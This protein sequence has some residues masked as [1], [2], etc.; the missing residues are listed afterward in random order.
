MKF[1]T[2][3]IIAVLVAGS[4]YLLGTDFDL[5]DK[6]A[7]PNVDVSV[8]A[9]GGR[10]P[11][12]DVNTPDISVNMEPKSVEVPDVDVSMEEKTINIPTVDFNAA[13]DSAIDEA[14]ESDAEER[15]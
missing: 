8:D 11:D 5:K 7:L 12:V 9:E 13:E 15:E 1:L 2:I 4:V 14:A 3:L 6:G 10:L